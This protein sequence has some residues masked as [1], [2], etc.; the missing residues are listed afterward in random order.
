MTDRLV[1]RSVTVGFSSPM[2]QPPPRVSMLMPSLGITLRGRNVIKARSR[3]L[4]GRTSASRAEMF[5]MALFGIDPA[6]DRLKIRAM[7]AMPPGRAAS[8]GERRGVFSAALGQFDELLDAAAAVGPASRP[9]PLYYALN[10]AGRA[11]AAALLPPDRPWRPI[12]H[13][14][15]IRGPEDGRLQDA[16]ITPQNTSDGRPGSFDLL[17]EVVRGRRLTAPTKLA[18]VWAAIPGLDKPG[19]GASCPRALPVEPVGGGDLPVLASLRQLDWLPVHPSS[20][21]RLH[22]VLVT[23]Y[24]RYSEGLVVHDVRYDPSA[25]TAAARAEVG[26]RSPDGTPR[27]VFMVTDS[28]LHPTSAWL[29]PVLSSGDTLAPILLWWCLLQALSSLARYHPAEWTAALDP[30][31]SRWAVS[32]E[33]AL[34]IGLDVVP[35]LVLMTLSPGAVIE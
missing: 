16:T 17:A 10:Q 1:L 31:R 13:G 9:V 7:R 22:E 21:N 4:G 25:D 30:D 34:R 12:L 2:H 8:D 11:I 24:P 32:I 15:S 20:G 19:L 27:T 28:Y 5:A 26:W 14:L 23:T 35:R 6:E 18:N 3:E 33:K 29:I